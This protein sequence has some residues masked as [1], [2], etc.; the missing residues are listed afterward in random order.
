M[1]RIMDPDD[2][3]QRKKSAG[4]AIPKESMKKAWRHF[5]FDGQ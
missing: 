5:G 4:R 2:P 3:V 1:L